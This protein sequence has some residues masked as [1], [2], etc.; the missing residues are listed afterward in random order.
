MQASFEGSSLTKILQTLKAVEKGLHVLCEK[1]LSTDLDEA[2]G[3]VDAAAKRPY[4]NQWIKGLPEPH[5][6]LRLRLKDR[7]QGGRRPAIAPQKVPLC[8]RCCLLV[9][10]G[11]VSVAP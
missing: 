10:R 4:V 1:P 3:V 11:R 5:G 9:R 6:R 2:Q 7:V 8:L